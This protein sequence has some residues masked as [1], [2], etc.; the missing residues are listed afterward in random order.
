MERKIVTTISNP[1]TPSAPHF[2]RLFLT[3]SIITGVSNGIAKVAMPL[4]AT[5]LNAPAWQMG[6]VGGLQ[7]VGTIV[8]SL[9][10]GAWVDR[11]GG[12]PL[13]RMGCIA[14]FM[15][16]LFGFT[17]VMTSWQLIIAVLVMGLI[18]PFRM[19]PTQAEFLHQLPRM[20]LFKAGWQRASHTM[21]M[22]FIGPLVGALLIST[23]GFSNTFRLV[24]VGFL[25]V[26]LLGRC[27]FEPIPSRR[28]VEAVPFKQRLRSQW[29]LV[30]SHRSLRHTMA[31][32]FA[33]QMSM[34]YFTIFVLLIGIRTFQMDTEI[35]ATLVSTNGGLFVFTLLLGG[36]FVK[37]VPRQAVYALAFL[38]MCLAHF[39]VCLAHSTSLLW[40]AAA[41]LGLGHGLQHLTSVELFA[42]LTQQLGRGRISGLTSLTGPMGNLIG[43]IG[44]GFAVQYFGLLAG[45]RILFLIYLV[46]FTLFIVNLANHKPASDDL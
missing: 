4:F 44:G 3:M 1:V 22:F 21:G 33:G 28:S 7:F 40:V 16:F 38:L 8:L 20:G 42:Q 12:L 29:S 11:H 19:V 26:L 6:L 35:A 41:F 24:A 45:F 23:L 10:V 13:F 30:R 15:L 25:V 37:N 34:T 14:A 43:A 39:M 2:L 31:I 5:A 32:E 46:L 27:V 18:N 9:P 17:Q 36:I